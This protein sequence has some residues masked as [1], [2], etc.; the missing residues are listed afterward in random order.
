MLVLTRKVGETLVIAEKIHVTVVCVQGDKVRLGVI[1]PHNVIVDREEIHQRRV[2][3]RIEA[4]RL[5]ADNRRL[6]AA[7]PLVTSHS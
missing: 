3:E 5:A 6:N 7:K 1:A 2:R 4:E